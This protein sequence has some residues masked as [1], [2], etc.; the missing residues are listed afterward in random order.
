MAHAADERGQQ[1]V[2]L[3]GA[4]RENSG[5]EDDA[6]HVAPLD[7]R[8]EISADLE[9]DGA[10]SPGTF[11]IEIQFRALG[12]SAWQTVETLPGD[13]GGYVNA[14]FDQP[15]AGHWRARYPGVTD[16]YKASTSSAVRVD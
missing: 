5:G 1:H 2:S 16:A 15:A 13:A 3:R 9:F 10:T 6:Q 8:H 4:S 11:P 12:A 7:V 14:T